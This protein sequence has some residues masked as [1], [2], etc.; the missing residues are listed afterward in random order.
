[1][2]RGETWSGY[3]LADGRPRQARP[4]TT[5]SPDDGAPLVAEVAG[6]RK[7]PNPFR[8]GNT[9]YA[10]TLRDPASGKEVG[11]LVSEGGP[12]LLHLDARAI[13]VRTGGQVVRYTVDRT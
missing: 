13:V 11:R 4:G 7:G 1:M 3:A 8:S 2:R 9:V 5:P 10:L 6:V 12:Q